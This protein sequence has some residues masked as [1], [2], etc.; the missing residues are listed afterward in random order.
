MYLM[1]LSF[2]T[3]LGGV[4]TVIGTSTNLVVSGLMVGCGMAPLGMFELTRVGLP[5]AVVGHRGAGRSW[6]RGSFPTAVPPARALQDDLREF[7]MHCKVV[8]GGALD[9]QTVESGRAAAPAGRVPGGGGARRRER[10]PPRPR[11]PCCAGGDRLAFAGRVDTVRD[12]QRMRGL[13]LGRARPQPRRST[14]PTTPSSRWWSSGASPLVGKTLT[15]GRVPRAVPG[16]GAG[17][18]PRR[19]AGERQAGRRAAQGGRHAAPALRPR[20]RDALAR[21]QRLSAG[22]Q[23]GRRAAARRRGRRCSWGW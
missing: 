16:G 3:I 22:V 7:V 14:A 19:A 11:P 23:A 2:A 5:V 20:L 18:P 6:R 15:R 13:V 8:P 9:G 21:P 4:V 17:H 1:P 10:S 12:L